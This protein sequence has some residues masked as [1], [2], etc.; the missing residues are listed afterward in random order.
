M[1]RLVLEHMAERPLAGAYH[2]QV[3]ASRDRVDVV[4][5]DFAIFDLATAIEKILHQAGLVNSII[6]GPAR[7]FQATIKAQGLRKESLNCW[8]LI[9]KSRPN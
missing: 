1:P 4:M 8:S 9:R 7:P 3:I 6:D 2:Q 5:G